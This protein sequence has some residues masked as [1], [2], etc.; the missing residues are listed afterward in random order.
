[1]KK[2][3][4]LLSVLL[5]A[6]MASATTYYYQDV[7]WGW[8]YGGYEDS[9]YYIIPDYNSLFFQLPSGGEYNLSFIIG[10]YMQ[11]NDV[12][13]LNVTP[14]NHDW[15]SYSYI[16]FNADVITNTGTCYVHAANN[17]G[18]KILKSSFS[19]TQI[20]ENDYSFNNFT[21]GT[22]YVIPALNRY[23]PQTTSIYIYPLGGS[24][25][26]WNQTGFYYTNFRPECSVSGENS[27]NFHNK[28]TS[29]NSQYQ[30]FYTAA[31]FVPGTGD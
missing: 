23:Y 4:F 22:L 28:N 8:D 11:D 9:L 25:L 24:D 29:D 3:L 10:G 14:S 7:G 1:M 27:I 16:N 26:S 31:T 13:C 20:G 5:L 18:I 19:A 12:H 15:L 2:L 21:A 17:V 30:D 6:G